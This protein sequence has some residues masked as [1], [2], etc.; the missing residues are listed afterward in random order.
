[1]RSKRRSAPCYGGESQVL[2]GR[3][4]TSPRFLSP[5]QGE[6]SERPARLAEPLWRSGRGGAS[7]RRDLTALRLFDGSRSAPEPVG[8]THGWTWRV[9]RSSDQCRVDGDR[10]R[11]PAEIATTVRNFASSSAARPC[12]RLAT[13]G[14]G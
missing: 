8:R 9:P 5:G 3:A 6:R 2:R 1:M 11:T 10:H 14:E 13:Y 4:R 12:P 7:H